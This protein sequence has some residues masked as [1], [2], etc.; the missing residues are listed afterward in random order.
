MGLIVL[1]LSNKDKWNELIKSFK[2]WDI[3]YLHEYVKGLSEF[4]DGEPIL[5]YYTSSDKR[6]VY[7]SMKRDIAEFEGFKDRIESGTFF[8][9]STPYGYGG[10]ICDGDFSQIELLEFSKELKNYCSNQGI[11]AEFT[12]FTPW[13]NNHLVSYTNCE[14]LKIRDTVMIDTNGS[15]EDI[16]T[17]ISNHHRRKIKQAQKNN[18]EIRTGWTSYL[19]EEFKKIYFETMDRNN[20]VDYYYFN[21]EFFNQ[22]KVELK[23]YATMFYAIKDKEI[24]AASIILYGQDYCHYH[25][26][27]IKNDYMNTGAMHLLIYKAAQKANQL[28]L[29]GLHLG[30]GYSSNDDSLFRFKKYFNQKEPLDFYIGKT[31][32][33]HEIYQELV[34]IRK[35][36]DKDFNLNS[37]FFPHYRG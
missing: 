13:N 31:I 6:L 1:D 12:R 27:G 10:I 20:A 11:V 17:S 22:M 8:D 24:I 28:G 3:Y 18:I 14:K 25:L 26:S 36:T 2:D 15:L 29:K 34:D 7:I 9:M 33:N 32:F 23:D 5:F 16:W 35:I 30:G 4:G 19:F 21:D 37:N